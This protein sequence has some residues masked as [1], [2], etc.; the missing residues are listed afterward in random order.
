MSL[1]QTEQKQAKTTRILV[2]PN[3][4]FAKDLEK[5]SYIQVI[6]KQITL[7]NEIRD[8]LWFYLILPKEVPSLVFDNVTQLIVYLPTHSPTMRAHFDTEAIKK[9]LPREYDFD[10]VM[11]HLPEHAYDLKNV[12][13]NKTQHVPKFFG[14]AHWFD[15]KEVVNWPM[16]SFNKSMIGL[17]EYDKCYI[18]TQHQKE[19]VLKQAEEIFNSDTLYKLSNILQVQ[20]IGVDSKDIVLDINE[21]T[22]KKIVFNHRPETYGGW[23]VATTDGMMN[24]VPYIM[25][26]DLYYEELN[27]DADF[28][29]NHVIAL[30]LLNKYLDNIEYRNKMADQALGCVINDLVY[31]DEIE[32]MSDYIDQLVEKLPCVSQTEK[33]DEIIEWI[34]K[35]KVISKK[36]LI[37]RLNW[38]VGIKFTQYRRRLLTNPN[39][40][41]T[42]SE[43]PNYCWSE[44]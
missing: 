26:G 31:K 19:M 5:D 16:D 43:Y 9:V 39:I 38:G 11:C 33:V 12:L 4:T 44:K 6:K 17:L 20:H 37:D 1:Y 24:G 18:N 22:F 7:L 35:E 25:Y 3:I 2:Y 10:L 21:K 8:D 27:E 41:D 42:I 36:N 28:F 23:S 30:D 13:Y 14:Y 40:Y 32:K 15:F 29:T 34:K